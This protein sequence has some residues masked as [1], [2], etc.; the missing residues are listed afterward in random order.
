MAQRT[1]KAEINTNRYINE[2]ACQAGSDTIFVQGRI[3]GR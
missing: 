2:R 1:I 3:V